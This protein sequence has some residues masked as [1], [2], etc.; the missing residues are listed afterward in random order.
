[1]C[2][3]LEQSLQ[4]DSSQPWQTSNLVAA[5]LTIINILFNCEYMPKPLQQLV[6]AFM[7]SLTSGLKVALTEMLKNADYT[8]VSTPPSA[9]ADVRERADFVLQQI[10]RIKEHKRAEVPY[11]EDH[12]T[13]FVKTLTDFKSA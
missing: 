12:V 5:S 9:R 6:P 11:F 3:F 8:P 4:R 2:R 10:A 1:M 13:A 7:P